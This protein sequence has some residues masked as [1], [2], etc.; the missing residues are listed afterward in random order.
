MD[1]LFFEN[2]ANAHL[3]NLVLPPAEKPPLNNTESPIEQSPVG[4][5]F[6]KKRKLG[7]VDK[8]EVS[9]DFVQHF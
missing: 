5:N 1:K 3:F 7:D 2:P 9:P 6:N 4:T 8:N